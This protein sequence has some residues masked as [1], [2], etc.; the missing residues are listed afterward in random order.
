MNKTLETGVRNA[1]NVDRY[2]FGDGAIRELSAFLKDHRQTAEDR[3]IFLVDEF[4][5]TNPTTLGKLPIGLADTVRYVSTAEEPTTDGIDDVVEQLLTDGP[6]PCVLV[7]IGGGIT[8]DTTKAVS[9][10]IANDGMAADYQGWDLVPGPGI[11][12]IGIPTLSGTGAEATRTCV[13]TN[14]V[15]GI[16]LGMNSDYTVFDQLILDPN[17]TITVP[18]E[19]YFFSGMDTWI[20]CL[21]A[22]NGEYRNPI[23]DAFSYQAI[24]LCH[25]VFAGGQMMSDANRASMMV[26]SYLGG[27]AIATSYVGVVHPFSAGLSVVLGLHHCVANCITMMAMAPFYPQAF[28]DFVKFVEHNQIDLPR[29]VCVGLTEEGFEAL[30]QATIIHE[31]PLTNALG[32]NFRKILT[33]DRVR[34]VFE[35]M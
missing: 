8:L 34:E 32:G 20:H 2:V 21:E 5:Q 18:S 35:A 27:C 17:L 14:R 25:E 16:K 9:N 7:G 12:K 30:Y 3:V 15:T 31:K 10:L 13:M 23:G 22:L 4:F 26:A 24:S 29:R 11:Y 28:D 19:Q 6:R 1:R 33:R